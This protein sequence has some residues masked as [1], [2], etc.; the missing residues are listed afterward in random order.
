MQGD[1]GLVV[2][3]EHVLFAQIMAQRGH[4][5]AGRSHAIARADL[6]QSALADSRND[7]VAPG[8]AQERRRGAAEPT[9]GVEHEDLGGHLVDDHE[10]HAGVVTDG[11]HPVG[12]APRIVRSCPAGEV[13]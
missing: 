9:V 3:P 10:G 7:V 1:A 8:E 5:P 12:Q 2:H 13:G 6:G 4:E 11:D